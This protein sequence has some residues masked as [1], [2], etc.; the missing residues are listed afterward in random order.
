MYLLTVS[1]L[2]LRKGLVSKAYFRRQRRLQ[3]IKEDIL[4]R[5]FKQNQQH[6][7]AD[8]KKIREELDLGGTAWARQ[9]RNLR[10]KGLLQPT[11]LRLT[12]AW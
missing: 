11:E 9:I 1:V 8:A 6:G 10:S 3:T 12:D 4:K 2:H 7:A 5:V